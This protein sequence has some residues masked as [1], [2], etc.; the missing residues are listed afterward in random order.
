MTG[1]SPELF[2]IKTQGGIIEPVT[3]SRV[4]NE[5]ILGHF[6]AAKNPIKATPREDKSRNLIRTVVKY[7]FYFGLMTLLNAGRINGL[8]PFG[9]GVFFA[10]L[11]LGE[12]AF[13]LAPL[14]IIS[15]FVSSLKLEA[16]LSAVIAG[17][18]V[19]V[20][21]TFTLL[22]KK[23]PSLIV[24]MLVNIVSQVGYL[25]F[26]YRAGSSI[27]SVFL[28]LVFSLIFFYVCING[29]K[30][31]FKYKLKFKLTE[32]ET[33]CIGIITAAAAVG[34]STLNI[35]NFRFLFMMAFFVIA[36]TAMLAG[37]SAGIVAGICFGIGSALSSYEVTD[38]AL[39][40]FIAA[41]CVIFINAP[42]IITSLSAIFAL[43]LFELYFNVDYTNILFDLISLSCGAFLYVIIPRSVLNYLKN[44][45]FTSHNK[46][47]ARHLVNRTRETL[48]ESLASV[49]GVFNE[50]SVVLSNDDK[51]KTE[52][53]KIIS[54]AVLSG[55]CQKCEKANICGDLIYGAIDELADKTIESGR[56]KVTDLKRLIDLNCIHLSHAISASNDVFNEIKRTEDKRT[57]DKQLKDELSEQ[58]I[59]AGMII[60]GAA[61]RIKTPVSYDLETEKIIIEELAAHD[62]IASE[63]LVEMS[64]FTSLTLIVRSGCCDSSVA[65]KIASKILKCE[66][67][68]DKETGSP[69]AGYRILHYTQVTVYDALFSCASVSKNEEDIGDK[70]SFIKIGADKFMMALSDGM[71]S[72]RSAG[73]VSEAAIT[74]IESYYRAGF[75]SE[76]VL[77]SVNRFLSYGGDETFAAL[78]I[79]VCDLNT[80]TCDII[81]IG[82]PSSYI[83]RADGVGRLDGNAL[84][85][86]MLGEMVPYVNTKQLNDGDAVIFVT[87]G[88]SDCFDGDT[89]QELIRDDESLNPEITANRILQAASAYNRGVP[90]D[91]M[92]VAVVRLFKRI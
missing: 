52:Y 33:A 80:L 19:I 77:S 11:F 35:G 81:K 66:L 34:I 22:L 28:N 85:L 70:H 5:K 75:P 9:T 89:L 68:L 21:H 76:L 83:K 67:A 92:T 57:K 64:D 74:L 42:R 44:F 47:A 49:A 65:G 51:P 20:Y 25:Y 38:I 7:I 16:L 73:K 71:G 88:V 87:D 40:G 62:I 29:L 18:V 58:L 15:G 39:L 59:G 43:V 72:G 30:P 53:K 84:P 61:D 56:A 12:N 46:L 13:I 14:F 17:G 32:V 78:D 79:L 48:S 2:D 60:R 50:M 31:V 91:D 26:Y 36:L 45:Y 10:L 37:K 63:A 4:R 27:L 3:P 1:K 86:G 41:C 90:A 8:S 69:I 54:N 6:E 23:K 24:L 82:S 55:I